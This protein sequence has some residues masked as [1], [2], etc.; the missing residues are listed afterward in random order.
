MSFC[1]RRLPIDEE[2]GKKAQK[3]MKGK[4]PKTLMWNTAEGIAVKP[5]YTAEDLKDLPQADA[6]E[7]P[8]QGRSHFRAERRMMLI[9]DLRDEF[10]FR[11]PLI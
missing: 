1:S 3:Q 5:I 11:W 7:L 8:G 2:W 6:A 10:L 4:D 9:S